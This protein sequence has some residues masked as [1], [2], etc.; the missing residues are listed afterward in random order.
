MKSNLLTTILSLFVLISVCQLHGTYSTSY[1]SDKDSI[2]NINPENTKQKTVDL[3]PN[4]DVSKKVYEYYKKFVIK[5][6]PEL[7]I[8][9]NKLKDKYTLIFTPGLFSEYPRLIGQQNLGPQMNFLKKNGFVEGVDFMR[10]P[11]NSLQTTGYNA[12]K[13]LIPLIAKS[14]RP[15][16][17]IGHS[18]GGVESLKATVS[19]VDEYEKNPTNKDNLLLK[20][21]GVLPIQAPFYGSNVANNLLG[22]SLKNL[23]KKE[24]ETDSLLTSL[25]KNTERFI[26]YYGAQ[27]LLEHPFKKIFGQHPGSM[28]TLV[29]L[30]TTTGTNYM[31]THDRQI[32]S[33]SSK[34]S[35]PVLTVIG[36]ADKKFP[37]ELKLNNILK[38]ANTKEQNEE[39]NCQHS[40]KKALT[41]SSNIGIYKNIIGALATT[42][43]EHARRV[44][45]GQTATDETDKLVNEISQRS[46]DA[47]YSIIKGVDHLTFVMDSYYHKVN[48]VMYIL[49][50]L[51]VLLE[52]IEDSEKTQ[53]KD[54]KNVEIS[55]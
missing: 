16:I 37:E 42:F 25:G 33:I 53:L 31:N 46:P 18:M 50:N 1:A 3:D 49:A 52:K 48:N 43:I 4:N 27:M 24:N 45:M 2:K 38:E 22:S 10:T 47:F 34:Y 20:I 35:I 8:L 55:L 19:S 13:K 5:D 54:Q 9:L 17:L 36:S 15:V 41:V 28:D 30:K 23:S 11:V 39:N 14:N 40:S 29:D 12:E 44:A 26:N 7:K 51:A 32:R 21:K 6:N